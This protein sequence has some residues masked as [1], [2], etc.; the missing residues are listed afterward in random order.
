MSLGAGGA[1]VRSLADPSTSGSL[2]SAVN[3]IQG[4]LL[5]SVAVVVA[6]LAVAGIGF[7]MLAGRVDVRRGMTVLVGSFLLLG[8]PVIAGAIQSLWVGG[9]RE[10]PVAIT[11]SPPVPPPPLPPVVPPANSDP[12][13]GASVPAR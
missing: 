12:Y 6:T 4:T 3:W 5:G 13:A 11:E 8:S 7:M 9:P 1:G 2:L 10:E